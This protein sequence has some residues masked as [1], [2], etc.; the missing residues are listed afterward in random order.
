MA[1]VYKISSVLFPER[2]YIGSSVGLFS[3]RRARHIRDLWRG[4]HHSPKLQNHYNKYGKDDLVFEVIERLDCSCG[5]ITAEQK[6]IDELD[7]YFNIRKKAESNLGMKHSQETKAKISAWNRQRR[8]S[9][10]TKKRI[11]EVQKGKI[12]PPET[13]ER[14]RLAKLGKK[15]G[16]YKA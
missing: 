11:S 6:W 5:L 15:R 14:M 8:H 2:I 13:R 4:K 3:S 1:L 12:I 7:P 16:S 10:E 9:D